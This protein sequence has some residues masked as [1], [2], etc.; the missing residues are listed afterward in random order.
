LRLAYN[1]IHRCFKC[2]KEG[3]DFIMKDVNKYL[4]NIQAKPDLLQLDLYID[5][6][7]NLELNL[8][9]LSKMV[10]FKKKKK[11]VRRLK[12][13]DIKMKWDLL[14]LKKLKKIVHFVET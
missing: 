4:D 5:I 8:M 13:K 12:K 3:Y 2:L 11:Q 14:N 1:Y 6:A 7:I 9:R 10:S